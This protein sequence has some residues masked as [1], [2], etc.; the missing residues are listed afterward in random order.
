MN[1]YITKLL[2][3]F[4]IVACSLAIISCNELTDLE[5]ESYGTLSPTTF[6]RTE[7]ELKAAITTVYYAIPEAYVDAYLNNRPGYV[8]NELPTDEMNTGFANPWQQWDRFQWEANHTNSFQIVFY[9]YAK[10]VTNATIALQY[11]NNSTVATKDKY[12]AELRALRAFLAFSLYDYFGPVPLITRPEEIQP[13]PNF[14]P[15]RPTKEEYLS[16]IETE[17]KESIPLLPTKAQT[18]P[19]EWGRMDQGAALTV[20]LKFYLMEKR[21]EDVIAT[22][23]KIEA[24]GYSL[25]D[26]YLDIFKIENEGK[27]NKEVIFAIPRIPNQR[28]SIGWNAYFLPADPK[29]AKFENGTPVPANALVAVYGGL[30]M[31]W[32]AYD[33]FGDTDARK[34]GLIRYYYDSKNVLIDYKAVKNAKATGAAAIKFGLD[35]AQTGERQGNDVICYRFADVLLAKAEALNEKNGLNQASI[36]LVNRI[37][38][39]AF[40][41]DKK[42]SLTDFA[43]KESFRNFILD[44]RLRELYFEGHRRQDLIRHDKF[45][46]NGV[47]EGWPVTEKHKLFPIPQAAMNDNPNLIQNPGY[48]N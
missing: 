48:E 30:R 31:P 39:R 24:Q 47:Q 5:F 7:E 25:W 46:A 29:I 6:P 16:F 3:T 8:L 41:T 14:K 43:S 26:N 38:K 20:L 28:W 15:A 18:L 19:A 1:N 33:K 9:N 4:G 35:P 27:T 21:W 32:D 40:G 11:A 45:V 42:Y 17:L 23:D 10:G 34:A 12:I 13:N 44:E 2:S 37:N 36:D 22:A